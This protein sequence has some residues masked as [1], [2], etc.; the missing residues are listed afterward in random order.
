MDNYHPWLRDLATALFGR[1]AKLFILHFN[2]NDYILPIREPDPAGDATGS[3]LQYTC[4]LRPFLYAFLREEWNYP[5]ILSY[6]L[7][8]GIRTEDLS[9]GIDLPEDIF[10]H[11]RADE[12]QAQSRAE[13]LIQLGRGEVTDPQQASIETDMR[14]LDGILRKAE[15]PVAIMMDYLERIVPVEADRGLSREQSVV[16]EMLQRWAYDPYLRFKTKHVV[17]MLTD[18]VEQVAPSVSRSEGCRLIQIPRPDDYARAR[19]LQLMRQGR[20][21]KSK[22]A[23]LS[24]DLLEE[25]VKR[26]VE[27]CPAYGAN[28]ASTYSSGELPDTCL[29]ERLWR[30]AR[31]GQL[32]L[33][34]LQK[35]YNPRQGAQEEKAGASETF[36]QIVP[37]DTSDPVS[38]L[39]ALLLTGLAKIGDGLNLVDLD[40]LNRRVRVKSNFAQAEIVLG[41]SDVRE[42]KG[43]V[44]DSQSHG[45][46]EVSHPINAFDDVGGLQYIKDYLRK[47]VECLK[48]DSA[49][50]HRGIVLVGPPGT[51]KSIIAEAL[52]KESGVNLIKM[53]E[54]RSMWVGESERNLALAL[55][56]IVS[57]QPVVVFVDEV[58]QALG[59]RGTGAS[60]DSGTSA[61]MFGRILEFMGSNEHRG[62]VFWVAASNRPDL[63]DAAL[64]RRFDMVVPLLMPNRT[65]CCQIFCVMP[66]VIHHRD[67]SSG[68]VEVK[69]QDFYAPEL[70]LQ[71]AIAGGSDFDCPLATEAKCLAQ[72]AVDTGLTGADIEKIVRRARDIASDEKVKHVGLNHLQKAFYDYKVNHDVDE[73]IL[74]SL[75]ALH[76]ANFY[77]MM[78]GEDLPGDRQGR[79]RLSL[80]PNLIDLTTADGEILRILDQSG[81][82][83]DPVVLQE[84]IVAYKMRRAR[85]RVLG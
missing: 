46:L 15:E 6:S 33:Q 78:P 75:I 24:Q 80:P 17:L 39:E 41:T 32:D 31:S 13:D 1:E 69:A 37:A 10:A 44:I 67:K 3:I 47:Q 28:A 45:L 51:G 8:N 84:A 77:S 66:R 56:L 63:L 38:L 9:Q 61:R 48:K 26:M 20:V 40:N 70:C 12:E 50:T 52:A 42:A 64:L 49:D 27:S 30:V 79:R 83:I 72:M 36:D 73:Y 74:Q 11:V 18:N 43:R 7:A 85:S 54:I 29:Q 53:R 62:K 68:E 19:F 55:D 2:I 16:I 60:G 65:E 23:T 14:V 4:L 76:C 21:G 22:L 82:R 25:E 34:E 35:A 59:A 58:D 5:Y 81:T 71:K 57:M